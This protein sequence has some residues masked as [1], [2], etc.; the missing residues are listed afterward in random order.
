[1]DTVLVL[2]AKAVAAGQGE[3]A[4]VLLFLGYVCT[5]FIK[6]RLSV[7]KQN[8]HYDV[9]M[10]ADESA[11]DQCDHI[12]TLVSAD[13]AYILEFRNGAVS[14]A[15]HSLLR[16]YMK[17]P[18][19]RSFDTN[20]IYSNIQGI[21]LRLILDWAKVLRLGGVVAIPEVRTL[22]HT[23]ND[24]YNLMAAH[25]TD[26]LYMFPLRSQVN[27][28]FFGAGVIGFCNGNVVLTSEQLDLL[29]REFNKLVH[30]MDKSL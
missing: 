17:Y 12:R 5:K 18:D 15:G 13:R 1:M 25:G 28:R 9:V 26:S 2:Y 22:K 8:K 21:P 4:L 14:I 20:S 16:M 7:R 19:S 24:R 30:L 27:G 10:E 23:Y 29:Q 3:L 6:A 11:A